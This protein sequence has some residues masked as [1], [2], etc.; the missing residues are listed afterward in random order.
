MLI[1]GGGLGNFKK[2]STTPPASATQSIASAGAA[3]SSDSARANS[4]IRIPLRRAFALSVCLQVIY[5][6]VPLAKRS[7]RKGGTEAV[8]ASDWISAVPP[9]WGPEGPLDR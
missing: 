5:A 9:S 3:D 4:G 7:H 6:L 2:T 1:G 8:L